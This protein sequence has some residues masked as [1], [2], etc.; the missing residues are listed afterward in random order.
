MG[1]LPPFRIVGVAPRNEIIRRSAH[2]R[3][4]FVNNC[5]YRH[6]QSHVGRRLGSRIQQIFAT[7]WTEAVA[8]APELRDSVLLV[9]TTP[10][11]RLY[12]KESTTKRRI[13]S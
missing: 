4:C 8:N 1:E 13:R 2:L 9:A 7:V 5:N 12:G 6:A 3:M 11:I 10:G